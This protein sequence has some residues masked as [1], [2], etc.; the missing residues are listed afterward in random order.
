MAE[1]E[2]PSVAF[3]AVFNHIVLPPQLPP[4][5]DND[6]DAIAGD[7]LQLITTS[8]HDFRDIVYDR[9]YSQLSLVYQSLANCKR[10]CVN[11]V[12]IKQIL[13]Q[14]LRSLEPKEQLIFH[15]TKQNA[16][17]LIR[18]EPGPNGDA[19]TFEAFE[20]SPT[21][22]KAL[23]AES[24][25]GW[26]FPGIAVSVPY[27]TFSQTSFLEELVI[28]LEQASKE[29][30]KQFAATTAK[31][32]SGAWESRDTVD[33]SLVTN[34]LMTLLEAT[35]TRIFPVPLRKRVRDEV[36]WS[37]GV[38]P[39]R[40]NPIWLI[41]RVAIHKHLQLLLGPEAGAVQYKFFKCWLLQ[42][43]LRSVFRVTHPE[44]TAI[45]KAKLCRRMAKLEFEKSNAPERL[46]EIYQ[47]FI[48]KLSDKIIASKSLADDHVM[49]VWQQYC[50]RMER[51]VVPLPRRA[52]PQDTILTLPN[53]GAYLF[54][55]LNNPQM[56]SR[57]AH[58]TGGAHRRNEVPKDG[59]KDFAVFAD[60]YYKLF[61]M[62]ENLRYIETSYRHSTDSASEK[63][64]RVAR[65]LNKYLD[66]LAGLYQGMS[67]AFSEAILNVMEC[68]IAI[69]SYA[70]QAFPL[71]A[72]FHP[73]FT[74]DILNALHIGNASDFE[75]LQRIGE[76][77]KLRVQGAAEH[78]SIF[79]DP[80]KG[81]FADRYVE[82]SED[83]AK[84]HEL[85]KQI[86]ATAEIS[87]LR[88][89]VEWENK[90][91]EYESL[92]QEIMATACQYFLS[93]EVP[94]IQYHDDRSCT[95]CYLGRKARRIR[96]TAHEHP[97]PTDLAHARAVLFELICPPA[98]AIY[99]DVTWR[100]LSTLALP[101]ARP[102]A[103]PRLL[104]QS[105]SELSIYGQ[106]KYS[107][108]SLASTKKSFLQ[109]HLAEVSMP[110]TLDKVCLPN[111][112]SLSYYDSSLKCWPGRIHLHPTFYHHF[113]LPIPDNSPF[114]SLRNDLDH[115][116]PPSSYEV[117]ASQT[118]CPA[119]VNVHEFLAYQGLLM[120]Y[121]RRFP[122]V[123]VEMASS[124]LNF[125]SE[126]TTL[127]IRYLIQQAGPHYPGEPLR[128]AHKIFRDNGFSSQLLT[129]IEARLQLIS[130]NWRE[131][132]C[133]DL[134]ITLLTRAI[135]I[136]S[137]N[138]GPAL[139]HLS[140][141]VAMLQRVRSMISTWIRSLRKEI[142]KAET[143]DSSRRFS[144][145]ALWA[146]LLGK[147]T[148]FPNGQH[149]NLFPLREQQLE[150]FIECS[151]MVQHSLV[152]K[153]SLL[154]PNLR[155]ALIRDLKIVHNI[156]D[157]LHTS[158]LEYQGA[159]S[160][161]LEIAWPKEEDA[162][163]LPLEVL[164]DWWVQMEI[165]ASETKKSQ[166]VLFHLLEGH[167]LLDG[168]PLGQLPPEHRNNPVLYI[169]FGNQNL[170]TI[171]SRLP[172][173][174]Y[175]ISR[176]TDKHRV[177]L[178]FRSGKLIVRAEIS[179]SLIEYVPPHVFRNDKGVEDLPASLLDGC[180]H[181]LDLKRHRGTLHVRQ[182]C[183]RPKQSDW[184]INLNTREA[185]RRQVKLVDRFS[186]V[187]KKIA[188]IFN[189]FEDDR[190]I[191][192][193][194]PL[195]RHLSVEMRRLE[196][197]WQVN[198]NG[199]LESEALQSHIDT[200]Q[201]AGTWYGLK[202]KIV[203][204]D[205]LNGRSRSIII[206]LGKPRS[207]LNGPHVEVELL[208]EGVYGRYQI[209]SIL[210]RIDCPP[211]PRLL[212][213]KALVHAYTS[214][215][216]PDRLT[217]RTG[218]EESL[219][220]LRS[221]Y[222]QPWSPLNPRHH[223]F[224]ESLANLTPVREYYPVELKVMQKVTWD[225]HLRS[226]AQNEHFFFVVKEIVAKSEQLKP[227]SKEKT[228]SLVLNRENCELYVRSKER[229]SLYERNGS[230]FSPKAPRDLS[231]NSRGQ[232]K[233]HAGRQNVY[234]TVYLL[235]NWMQTF[236]LPH[237]LG[238]VLEKWQ[239]IGGYDIVLD[240][241]VLSDRL[242]VDLPL[243]W[244]A[245]VRLCQ[246]SDQTQKYRLMFLFATLTYNNNVDMDSIRTL[247]SFATNPA[248]KTLALPPG[249][250]YI[251]FRKI[252]VV[253]PDN[254]KL[255]IKPYCKI[256]VKSDI[257]RATGF[258]LNAKLRRKLEAE[259]A[260]FNKSVEDEAN[261][262]IEHLLQQ[263][264]CIQPLIMF[265]FNHELIDLSQMLPV[266]LPE[267]SRLYF[268]YQLSNHIRDVQ[269]VLD[270]FNMQS[271]TPKPIEITGAKVETEKKPRLESRSSLNDLFKARGPSAA[272]KVLANFL[273]SKRNVP[274]SS[275]RELD[276]TRESLPHAREIKELETIIEDIART[277]SIVR[278][279]YAQDL[280]QS[281]TAFKRIS[282][283]ATSR[284]SML[285]PLNIGPKIEE[286]A[287][288][289]A[290]MIDRIQRAL[291][292]EDSYMVWLKMGDLLPCVT[293]VSLLEALR[294]CNKISFGPN[295][296]E[297]LLL[298]GVS[299]TDL[300]QL[301][302]MEAYRLK[303]DTQRIQEEESNSGHRNWDPLDYPDW[304]LLEIDSNILIRPDQVEVAH[305]TIQ[306]ASGN[307]SVLQ[308][309]MGQGKTSC[310]MPM[311]AAMLADGKR[312]LRVVVPRALLLQTVQIIHARLGGLVGREVRHVPFSRQTPTSTEVIKTFHEIHAKILKCS[313]LMISLPEHTLSF[314]LSGLQRLSDGRLEEAKPMVRIQGWLE[315]V[316]RD[317]LDESD[318][319]LA[320]RT[321]LI[322]PSGSQ[323]AFDGHPQRWKT[324]EA[325]L[326]LVHSYLINL[327]AM[328]PR[329]L[330]VVERTGGGY[331]F[332][333][334]LRRDAEEA[335]VKRLV[336]DICSG[337]TS[338]LPLADAPPNVQRAVKQ[339]ISDPRIPPGQVNEI[340]RL[341]ENNVAI[342][343]TIY[344]L[345]G[346]FV[347]RI[348]LLALKKRWNV[349]Y[350]LH[351]T[352]DPV[353]VPYHA[354]GVP[355][356][357]AEWGHPDVA[358]LFTCLSFYYHGLSMEQLGQSLRFVL[359]SDD[360]ASEYDRWTYSSETLPGS[361]REWNSI[362]VDDEVQLAEI[363]N[364]VRY[365]VIV[366]DHYLNN[367]V[368]PRHAKQFLTKLQAS[369]WDI[370]LFSNDHSILNKYGK[371]LTT[372]FSGT[373]DNK[374]MLP[375]TIT[376]EDL[377]TLSHTNAEVLTYLLQP[378]NRS[379]V[380]AANNQGRRWTE[381]TLL[382][383]LGKERIRILI[384]AGA[385]ILEMDNRELVTIWMEIDFQAP[386]AIYFDKTN[387]PYVLY[388]NGSNVPLLATPYAEDS[389]DCLIYLDES[390][391]RGTDL[392]MP[393]HA[394]GALTLG[395]GQT[396][397]H[398]VQAA[399][400]LRQL[401]TTQSVVFFAPPEVHQ[402]IVDT[403]QKQVREEVDSRDVVTWLLHQTCT[404][405]EQL[406]PLYFSQGMDFCR[407]IQ[408]VSDNSEFL[409]DPAHLKAYLN[410][411]KQPEQQTLRQMYEP[412]QSQQ[413]GAT[414]ENPSA[415]IAKF[416]EE[417]KIR[418]RG[419]QDTGEAVHG[420]ALQEV[421]QEREV[422]FEVESVREVQ[423]P[424]H[425]TPFKF[426]GL[427]KD[428]LTFLHS[429]RLLVGAG[430]YEPAFSAL[431]RICT[432][433]EK[434]HV[435]HNATSGYLYVS[436]EFTKA[437]HAP[438]SKF[439]DNFLRPVNWILVGT[440]SNVAI[441]VTPEESEHLI[442]HLNNRSGHHSVYL[443]TYAAPVT[444]KMVQ[445]DSL[446][447]LTI[448][449][450][451]RDWEPPIKLLIEL[452]IFA[453]RLYFAYEHA[454]ALREYLRL[455]SSEIDDGE[456]PAEP[457]FTNRPL[458]F[459]QEWL[460]LKRKG[461]DFLHTPMGHLCQ[462]KELL[463]THPFFQS[464]A[465][466]VAKADVLVV[467][468][469]ES[470]DGDLTEMESGEDEEY[471]D[472]DI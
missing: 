389:A 470:N 398:T 324:A 147:L 218:T 259:E 23:E 372:G 448:P 150:F 444:R 57:V 163:Y 233:P 250:Q 265:P 135:D 394:R 211:E 370:P 362:N 95:K 388:R 340:R 19:V 219:H 102:A 182:S 15:V 375:L 73:L 335:L 84:F 325:L 282:S 145:F 303:N 175:K 64:I 236:S 2:G 402:S 87:R 441:I 209:N 343:K 316:S 328:Y 270:L 400:R 392:K 177:H 344:L 306:P 436:A 468:E 337:R 295:M 54:N 384:D 410:T 386:A 32:A 426:P 455:D 9:Y 263:W 65:L 48:D 172:G 3:E 137:L 358:I 302:R 243:F 143:T 226:H 99:R 106:K 251:N 4:K 357:Q 440:E 413:K 72:E 352:R 224:L 351:P 104:L 408:A 50:K 407:R 17:I 171:P 100:I 184:T 327:Q 297:A 16:A 434:Y 262:L 244:G 146:A 124:N 330:E 289:M 423:K 112:L 151:I 438:S 247:I 92:S 439:N 301:L 298:L 85:Y 409:D 160:S 472:G 49:D 179:G 134:L 7:L 221:G 425:F 381:R 80:R 157:L 379:Y 246:G 123:L 283:T 461:Q 363:W 201:D 128:I 61:S 249:N 305:A 227:F 56:N 432:L 294:S 368:F 428:L 350:G 76:Y 240:K 29:S 271:E 248:L 346:L 153:P 264:P 228:E 254:L 42:D 331:P 94:P 414:I 122:S 67:G 320:V 360:P 187:F 220:C 141:G 208:N 131:V 466:G 108:V 194:Q 127:L 275:K 20:A 181:W 203:L 14:Q 230:N 286:A 456:I 405:I 34:L 78:T 33:P 424:V 5:E 322:Y 97:L 53:S 198:S 323:K 235:D 74:P 276:Q 364:H 1:T 125:S 119:G 433:G 338:I 117:I 288:R 342:I 458:S 11:G 390:H 422:A 109:T 356:E 290:V 214:F 418:R 260:K 437:V 471:V 10:V 300:Q 267:W 332:I 120:G 269:S 417:L 215:V 86:E 281:V 317:I 445:F 367:F 339:F 36:S 140:R 291:S 453:G 253:R 355:S 205:N 459:L 210:G 329:S 313:G 435:D 77:L 82:H 446:R 366:I 397:D 188:I 170:L 199:L 8:I 46:Q 105:Y 142:D 204:R 173:M 183:W 277:D 207:R 399:M 345:R 190:F 185:H 307:N 279:R 348:L 189:R 195:T 429:G 454:N 213:T 168:K 60:Q 308:M 68:W 114:I 156:K 415:G 144:E 347:H 136:W 158:I 41:L 115:V 239:T 176:E 6:V 25:L 406:Q 229:R 167:L 341:F 321:Q 21:S 103:E 225:P 162:T 58:A 311:A 354:K 449:A 159:L 59:R 24:A 420:S 148:F 70:T 382:V 169:L 365:S 404:G 191:T 111:G 465:G 107:I 266:I 178:G 216:V 30:I 383:M 88:K 37:D 442:S 197:R 293:I 378:R 12:L 35:G 232:P 155:F 261:R 318:F 393:R 427:H 284:K 81:C 353:A 18:R 52:D 319:T 452:G 310:I 450:M 412:K 22:Q 89:E 217:G 132:H 285:F 164:P 257:Q 69:D 385:Q 38:N 312:L 333:Y 44:R 129:Q 93:N 96:I 138:P 237:D 387:K 202:S 469:E 101:G 391:T 193:F 133:M 273:R 299:I 45:L 47:Y 451:E 63:C 241:V 39:W 361:L 278:K 252:S 192:A 113:P 457:V 349:Q 376:Q 334:F 161:A 287:E 280:E 421:E 223:M 245:L 292:R 416:I 443:L 130:S 255:L 403:Q 464:D 326:A 373:N 154:S 314:M 401:G 26:D 31:A 116:H 66:N 139:Q 196:L 40:R 212:Y 272:S 304:L 13:L 431:R 463:P 395:L 27:S 447:F 309:N 377:P 149:P 98:F 180:F 166:V 467:E 396:K 274:V 90:S 369:G 430:G 83:S 242:S 222:C 121:N 126:T 359:Q 296:R 258:M 200:N 91:A 238:S 231:Y 336:N 206:P 110:T 411:L 256:Y 43:F 165:A 315:R 79:V 55:I 234:E 380:L 51:R 28:F 374:T 186:S 174:T 62:E 419:F 460:T 118:R 268:N 71:L 371:S 462:S 75:R 152:A